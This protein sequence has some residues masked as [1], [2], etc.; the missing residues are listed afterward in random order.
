M[1]DAR[2]E[3][4][5]ALF[6]QEERRR[7]APEAALK[8]LEGTLRAMAERARVNT[9]PQ[10]RYRIMCGGQVLESGNDL[11]VAGKPPGCY[12]SRQTR[13]S[14]YPS[15]RSFRSGLTSTVIPGCARRSL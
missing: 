11:S 14:A 15:I 9:G 7:L 8:E 1:D 3:L 5:R 12:M 4:I 10:P 2:Q 6:A 13:P